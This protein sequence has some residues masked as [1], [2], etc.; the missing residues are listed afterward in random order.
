MKATEDLETKRLE[1]VAE[2]AAVTPKEEVAQGMTDVRAEFAVWKAKAAK[3]GTGISKFVWTTLT[4]EELLGPAKTEIQHNHVQIKEKAPQIPDYRSEL[5]A[6]AEK[7]CPRDQVKDSVRAAWQKP[8][9]ERIAADNEDSG[10]VADCL[11]FARHDASTEGQAELKS[12][13]MRL[14]EAMRPIE[15]ILLRRMELVRAMMDR[16]R[17]EPGRQKALESLLIDLTMQIR[18][19]GRGR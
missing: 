9:L 10:T 12:I 6:L 14:D 13:K 15:T 18:Q 5:A 2:T 11:R 7:A 19:S 3:E 17:V 8:F 4:D 1:E 16:I